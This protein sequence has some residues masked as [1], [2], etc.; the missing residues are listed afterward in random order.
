MTL[1]DLDAL[2]AGGPEILLRDGLALPRQGLLSAGIDLLGRVLRDPARRAQSATADYAQELG[3]RLATYGWVRESA[4]VAQRLPPRMRDRLLGFLTFY[5]QALTPPQRFDQ[6]QAA[7][8]AL[9]LSDPARPPIRRPIDPTRRVTLG[10]IVGGGLIAHDAFRAWEVALH[11]RDRF[12]LIHYYA[13]GAPPARPIADDLWVDYSALS[14]PEFYDRVVADGVDLLIDHCDLCKGHRVGALSLRP[15]PLQIGRAAVA[16][17]GGAHYD[18]LHVGA[19][20]ALDPALEP[21][22]ERLAPLR[23]PLC[24]RPPVIAPA[25][26]RPLG[27]DAPIRFGVF[28]QPP[29]LNP[30]VA[31]AWAAILRAVPDAILI[32]KRWEFG[33]ADAVT[34]A[35]QMLAA[36]GAPL[37]RLEFRA[38]SDYGDHL[39]AYA[40]IDLALDSFPFAGHTTTV[41]ALAMGTPVIGLIG[42]RIVGRLNVALTRAAGCG[43]L[44]AEDVEG[45][46]RLAVGFATDRARLAAYQNGLAARVRASALCDGPAWVPM[47][48]TAYKTMIE[49]HNARW[50]D[51]AR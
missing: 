4:L 41:E 31:A 27:P 33:S 50:S 5:D 16:S 40:E 47:L 7:F 8:A 13:G 51:H 17:A 22:I 11:D 38:G 29:K 43:D 2:A 44:L 20:L 24:W 49:D 18:Y 28:V 35:R 45:Y 37:E 25:P 34:R 1:P 36:A 14:H 9:S 10:H 3:W 15:A 46:V 23:Q 12:R 32:W 6:R 48:E 42:D 26:R 21:L 19:G 30:R 39:A